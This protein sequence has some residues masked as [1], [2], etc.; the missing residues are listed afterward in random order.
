MFYTD[1]KSTTLAKQEVT[2][3]ANQIFNSG[4]RTGFITITVTEN[5]V[6]AGEASIPTGHLY[7]TSTGEIRIKL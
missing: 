5:D 3:P 7:K 1:L 2:I 6:S 4:D